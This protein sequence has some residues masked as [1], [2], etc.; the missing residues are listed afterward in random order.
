MKV[1]IYYYNQNTADGKLV[2]NLEPTYVGYAEVEEFNAEE[3]WELCN[4]GEWAR[5]KPVNLYSNISFCG[6]GLCLVNPETEERW[7][8]KSIGWLTGD[9]D[10]IN[11]YVL[12]NMYNLLW[13]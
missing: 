4:W 12:D 6:H 7:L 9:E 13:E 5:E 8:A 3:I 1:D 10:T 2:H 11:K